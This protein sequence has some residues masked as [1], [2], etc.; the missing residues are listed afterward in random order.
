MKYKLEEYR[1]KE[2]LDSS[3]IKKK[4]TRTGDPSSNQAFIQAPAFFGETVLWFDDPP[5][6]AYGAKCL[7][8]AELTT[9][10]KDDIEEMLVDLPYVRP[11]FE[12]FKAHV[13]GQAGVETTDQQGMPRYATDASVIDSGGISL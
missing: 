6:R 5:P 7:T 9:M 10:T 12:H 1:E 8:R 11:S 4:F 3:S 2:K 13:L